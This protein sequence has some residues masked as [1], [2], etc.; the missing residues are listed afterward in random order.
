[1]SIREEGVAP[2]LSPA[3]PDDELRTLGEELARLYEARDREPDSGASL[4]PEIAS[5]RA[6]MR[7]GPRLQPGEFVADGRYW[8]IDRLPRRG[9]DG[10]FKSWDRAYGQFVNVRVF[11]GEWVADSGAIA[12]FLERGRQLTELDHPGIGKVL[13][14]GQTDDGFVFLATRLLEGTSL[15]QATSLDPIDAVQVMVELGRALVAAHERGVVHGDLRPPNVVLGGDGSVNLMGFS[16]A[17]ERGGRPRLAV[18][19]SRDR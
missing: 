9:V 8:L 18:S 6:R 12:Q 10:H 19:G 11:H 1:M 4:Q 14:A 15:E 2:P 16:V 3:Y 5:V 17:A 7:K 13:D